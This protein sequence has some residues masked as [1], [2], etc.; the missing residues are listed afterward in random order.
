MT[1]ASID[2][3]DECFILPEKDANRLERVTRALILFRRN[4]T[5]K[6]FTI[7]TLI[8]VVLC[9]SLF[10]AI[11]EKGIIIG[12]FAFAFRELLL[13]FLIEILVTVLLAKMAK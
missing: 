9:A 13:S 7:E 4:Q 5:K 10:Q 8:M 1:G 6:K 11:G 2:R 12:L 3:W